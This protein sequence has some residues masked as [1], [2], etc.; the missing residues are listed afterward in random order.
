MAVDAIDWAVKN[1]LDVISLSLGSV[2]GD[3]RS[4]DA[5]AADNA[6]KAGVVV[7]AAAG[8]EGPAAYINSVPGV[9]SRTIEVAAVDAI[10]TFP[11]ATIDV[12]SGLSAIVANEATGF[13]VSGRLDVLDR[14]VRGDQPGLLARGLRRACRP[15]TSWSPC[16]ATVHGPTGRR[17]ARPP[18][19]PP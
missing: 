18:A 10:P 9:A 3:P 2:F 6:A 16:E 5:V 7:V 19:R 8:N 12:G 15:A 14:R 11:G 4:A 13:P 1:H 17:S